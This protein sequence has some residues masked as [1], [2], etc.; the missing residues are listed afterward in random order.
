MLIYQP[1]LNIGRYRVEYLNYVTKSPVAF[2]GAGKTHIKS[3]VKKNYKIKYD[4]HTTTGSDK[5]TL[6]F[7]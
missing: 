2:I 4:L 3:Q 7:C 6:S 1:D 5:R